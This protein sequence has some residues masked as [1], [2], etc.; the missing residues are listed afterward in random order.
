MYVAPTTSSLKTSSLSNGV[1]Q[2][3]LSSVG[4]LM[5]KSDLN[6]NIY[7]LYKNADGQNVRSDTIP[8]SKIVSLK[9][10][11]AA[12][13][14]TPL[15]QVLI[16]VDT[17]AVT[18][19]NLVGKTLALT[20]HLRNIVSGAD[21]DSIAVVATVVGNSTNTASATAFHKAL[22]EA[23]AKAL[24][25]RDIPPIRVFS[26]STEVSHGGTATGAAAGVVLT[27]TAQKF[28]LGQ[29][30]NTPVAFDVEFHYATD[31]NTDVQ[32][33]TA[34][35][36][37]STDSAWISG[38]AF[39]PAYFK[40][41]ELE[42]FCEGEKGDVYR[43]YRF[44]NDYRPTLLVKT[45]GTVT[46]DMLTIDY[47]WSGEGNAVQQSPRTLHIAAPHNNTA[48]DDIVTKLYTAIKDKMDLAAKLDAQINTATTGLEDRVTALENA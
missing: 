41:A 6:G 25:K 10:N 28:I 26:N 11:V 44:P 32:W 23:I 35:E 16:A 5:M 29:M 34:T 27:Q 9:K 21:D 8:V 17:N 37:V 14:A 18:L 15:K 3:V 33:G 19:A 13:L 39:I 40:I 24:P 22:A 46:Y 45:D 38:Q 36:L 42:H 43:G 20:I 2:T 47:F 48:A 12:D 4:D 7:F 1:E 31:N 30:S